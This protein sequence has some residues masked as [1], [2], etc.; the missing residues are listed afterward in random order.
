MRLSDVLVRD[1]TIYG[2]EAKTKE[3]VLRE[4]LS[5]IVAAGKLAANR[6]DEVMEA[7]MRRERL[8]TTGVGK[9]IAVPHAKHDC[10]DG[11]IA[12][13]GHSSTG[14]EFASLDNEPVYTVF[15]LLASPR[16][17]GEHLAA[18]ERISAVVRDDD[19]WRFLRD[20][21]TGAEILEIIGEAD[22]SFGE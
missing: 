3:P 21:K 20:A 7:L 13:I 9:G 8:G 2:L 1:A 4:M 6:S 16:A 19:Y 14:V 11:I 10:I 5:A 18:L 12:S 15:L 17:T 22:A